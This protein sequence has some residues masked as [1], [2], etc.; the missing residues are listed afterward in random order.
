[1][2]MRTAR[3]SVTHFRNIRTY[4]T[5]CWKNYN[6]PKRK[7]TNRLNRVTCKGCLNS[8]RKLKWIKKMIERRNRTSKNPQEIID[9]I[10]YK[11]EKP[12]NI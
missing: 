1:M 7:V 8:I 5:I 2:R 6:V 10:L 12:D 3:L 9:A 11:L 4:K